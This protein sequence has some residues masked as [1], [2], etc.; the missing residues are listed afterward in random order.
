MHQL[1]TG[2]CVGMVM[3]SCSRDPFDKDRSSSAIFC[4]WTQPQ[5][6][7]IPQTLTQSQEHNVQSLNS[8]RPRLR[9]SLPLYTLPQCKHLIKIAWAVTIATKCNSRIAALW[10][11]HRKKLCF[12]V[13]R[14]WQAPI[15]W[16]CCGHVS[17]PRGNYGPQFIR[18]DITQAYEASNANFVWSFPQFDWD[19]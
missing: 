9:G 3:M 18:I 6:L 4:H 7:V 2:V 8:S 15:A 19:Y 16:L 1:P 10:S 13:L 14:K 17:A 12:P 5:S 11:L